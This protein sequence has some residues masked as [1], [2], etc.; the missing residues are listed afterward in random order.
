MGGGRPSGA[1]GCRRRSDS[2]P[3]S[4][5]ALDLIVDPHKFMH[6]SKFLSHIL[7]N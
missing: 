7:K 1:G 5:R 6:K 2:R 3:R 4:C